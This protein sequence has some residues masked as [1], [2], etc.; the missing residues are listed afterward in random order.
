M[1]E[2]PTAFDGAEDWVD[3]HLALSLP[4][5]HRNMLRRAREEK[6][7]LHFIDGLDEAG[8]L[9][10]RIEQHFA[11]VLAPQGHAMLCTSR[12]TGLDKELFSDFHRLQLKPLSNEQQSDFLTERLGNAR[13]AELVPY[14]ELKVPVDSDK[15]R[16]TANPLMLSMVAS[17]AELRTGVDMPTTTAALYQT[18]AELMLRRGGALTEPEEALLQATFLEAH[19]AQQ[20]IITEAHLSSAAQKVAMSEESVAILCSRVKQDR[21][22]LLRLTGDTP[23]QM[24]AFHLSFQEYYAM[25]AIRAGACLPS[26]EWEVWWTNSVLMGVQ[27]GDT[28][29]NAFV[30]AAGLSGTGGWR[31]SIVTAIAH[32]GLPTAWLQ[33]VAEAAGSPSDLPKL[34]QFAS[35]YG[36]ILQRDGGRAV[37]QLALQQP[38]KGTVFNMLK[39][40]PMQ[41]LLRWVNKPQA[42]PC[43]AEFSHSGSV[44]ALAVSKTILVCGAGKSLH[45]YDSNTYEKLLEHKGKS[46]V[47]AVSLCDEYL[48][49]GFEDGSLLVW[50]AGAPHA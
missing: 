24:Q 42:D 23:L 29:G 3:V 45:V 12:P 34:K 2:N 19:I 40:T 10:A 46:D 14:L 30:E 13:G 26:F 22:P 47:K 41:P 6:C 8:K 18:A 31:S 9:R 20:R 11:K 35:R 32:A 17:I 50:D 36:D 39:A 37:A 25:R 48:A 43:I 21:L 1:T 5:P 27:T 28:F 7:A 33:T 38:E 16:V 15:R 4:A 44:A 49:A